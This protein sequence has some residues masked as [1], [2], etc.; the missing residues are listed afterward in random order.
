MRCLSK[1]IGRYL[2]DINIVCGTSCRLSHHN[3]MFIFLE[4]LSVRPTR[5]P[6]LTESAVD[7]APTPFISLPPH[8]E[9]DGGSPLR[10][11]RGVALAS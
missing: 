5:M 4:V 8:R 3:R 1:P 2:S 9:E 6:T 11:A 10:H 7:E